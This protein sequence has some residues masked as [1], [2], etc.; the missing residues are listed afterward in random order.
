MN[1]SISVIECDT[2]YDT[3]IDNIIQAKS[4]NLEFLHGGELSYFWQACAFSVVLFGGQ[5]HVLAV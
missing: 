1:W 3:V 4:G 2:E 5:I